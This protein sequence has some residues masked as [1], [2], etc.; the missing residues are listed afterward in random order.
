[1]SGIAGFYANNIELRQKENAY[2]SKCILNT[3][4]DRGPDAL[5]SW[6]DDQCQLL[7]TCFDTLD[8][9]NRFNQPFSQSTCCLL[10]TSD[11]ATIYSV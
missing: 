5:G 11:A 2:S 1:M 9:D 10:Y 8:Q 3:L 6:N 7:H 4:K